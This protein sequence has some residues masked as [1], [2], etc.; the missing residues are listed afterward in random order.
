MVGAWRPPSL[1]PNAEH[2]IREVLEGP[3]S[4][5]LNVCGNQKEGASRL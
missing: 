2:L 4:P 3:E 1:P 5:E